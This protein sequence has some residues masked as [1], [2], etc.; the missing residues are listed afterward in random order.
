MTL[1][2]LLCFISEINKNKKKDYCKI[3]SS[4]TCG[5]WGGP[6]EAGGGC[7]G[8]TG[9]CKGGPGGRIGC[10][11]EGG[12]MSF[13]VLCSLVSFDE[14]V[15]GGGGGPYNFWSLVSFF[16]AYSKRKLNV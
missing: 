3:S 13:V 1:F 15:G 10:C 2:A 5:G 14:D 8:V 9:G 4:I 7:V 6:S 16:F 12:G 11:V